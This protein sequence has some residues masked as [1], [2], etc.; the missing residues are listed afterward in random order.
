MSTERRLHSLSIVRWLGI[1]ALLVGLQF[2]AFQRSI[3]TQE[4]AARQN[5]AELHNEVL[6]NRHRDAA[7]AQLDDYQKSGRL[8][9]PA[10]Q[11]VQ[12]MLTLLR[13]LP[14]H[15]DAAVAELARV[16]GDFQPGSSEDQHALATLRQGASKLEAIYSNHY[17][18][19]HDQVAKPAWYFLPA[20]LLSPGRGAAVQ[21]LDMDH[22][23]YLMLVGQRGEANAILAKL[24]EDMP[25][26]TT[27]AR[28]RF[29]Q[30]RLHYDSFLAE[31]RTEYVRDSVEFAR[32]SVLSDSD[33]TLGKSFLDFLLA[34]HSLGASAQSNP[35]QV[36]GTGESEGKR[37][38][39]MPDNR[40]F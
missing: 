14:E 12:R 22:A 25:P 21:A 11:A 24:A 3:A 20:A 2:W 29:M 5:L 27:L 17:A 8:D 37:G 10:S 18:S 16:A 15:A 26:G 1:L 39:M 6:D 32:E 40:E 33:Y 9:A 34:A 19:L 31:R 38:S 35:V 28:I 30:S 4:R 23:L 7:L 36:Q 13:S